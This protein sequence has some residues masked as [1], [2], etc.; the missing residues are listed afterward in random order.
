MA[1][2]RSFRVDS[3]G[4]LRLIFFHHM[5]VYDFHVLWSAFDDISLF[6][7]IAESGHQMPDC[8]QEAVVDGG[9][10]AGQAAVGLRSPRSD[11]GGLVWCG[12]HGRVITS[13]RPMQSAEG[14]ADPW[15]PVRDNALVK[16]DYSLRYDVNLYYFPFTDT[17]KET[18]NLRRQADGCHGCRGVPFRVIWGQ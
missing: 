3:A 5:I 15:H 17:R 14:V 12:V 1:W 11:G 6:S 9:P 8:R 16:F 2:S 13:I 4:S 10:S 7:Q 18:P